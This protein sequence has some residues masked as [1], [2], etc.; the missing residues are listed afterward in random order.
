MQIDYVKISCKE[1]VHIY[2]TNFAKK[3]E[4]NLHERTS[5]WKRYGKWLFS[6]DLEVWD[7]DYLKYNYE[8]SR[9]FVQSSEC[10]ELYGESNAS[11]SNLESNGK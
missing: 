10:W 4:R 7:D 5:H 3:M 11:I 6:E 9:I 8:N 2:D 1:D